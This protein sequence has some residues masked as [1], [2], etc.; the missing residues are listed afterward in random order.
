M[1]SIFGSDGVVHRRGRNEYKY[2]SSG[3][4]VAVFSSPFT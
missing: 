2:Q 4:N 3:D 1:D